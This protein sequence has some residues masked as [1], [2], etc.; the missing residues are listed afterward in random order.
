MRV[1]NGRIVR[2]AGAVIVARSKAKAI[3]VL[4]ADDGRALLR[5]GWAVTGVSLTPLPAD[6]VLSASERDAIRWIDADLRDGS[7]MA[8]IVGESTPDAIVHLAGISFVPAFGEDPLAGFRTNVETTLSLLASVRQLRGATSLNPV[9]LVIGSAEQYG[10]HE[11]EG[12]LLTEASEC[13]PATWYAA[14]K[15]AQETMAFFSR[16]NKILTMTTLK[17]RKDAKANGGQDGSP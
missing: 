8:Q 16:S 9:V 1:R 12:G 15:A 4:S 5:E 11:P 14:A 13:R 17:N 6:A 7:R 10:R 2:I 3:S